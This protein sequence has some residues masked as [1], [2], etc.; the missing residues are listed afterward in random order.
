MLR[1]L[2]AVT[3]LTALAGSA[4]GQSFNV[5]L[6][7]YSFD[8]GSLEFT[9][10]GLAPPP[11]DYWG[12]GRRGYWNHATVTG[13]AS[14]NLADLNNQST[15]VSIHTPWPRV[16]GVAS[17]NTDTGVFRAMMLD[18]FQVDT[19]DNQDTYE[20]HNLQPGRYAVYVYF[21]NSPSGINASV[22]VSNVV[23][24]IGPVTGGSVADTFRFGK[25]YTVARSDVAADGQ[26]TI[27]VSRIGG[28]QAIVSAMQIVKLDGLRPVMHINDNATGDNSGTSWENAMGSLYGA[29]EVLEAMYAYET[30]TTAN[31]VDFD[32]WVAGGVYTATPFTSVFFTDRDASLRFYDG[33]RIFGGFAGTENYLHQR[34]FGRNTEVIISGSIGGAGT[35]D[36]TRTLLTLIGCGDSTLVE[37]VTISG[38]FDDE[39]GSA[40][41]AG[42]GGGVEIIPDS[43]FPSVGND[44]GPV[45][46]DVAFRNN[47]ALREGGA[48]WANF[49][50]PV[51]ERCVFEANHAKITGNTDADG[52]AVFASSADPVFVNCEFTGNS[53]WDDGAAVDLKGNGEEAQLV[54][55]LMRGN[56]G[57]SSTLHVNQSPV[58]IINSL[59]AGNTNGFNAAAVYA[60]GESG[61]ILISSSTVAHNKALGDSSGVLLANGADGTV[62]NSIVWGNSGTTTTPG[63][64][65]EDSIKVVNGPTFV[66]FANST[67]E[68]GSAMQVP[69]NTAQFMN[70]TANPLFADPDG[71]DG[72]LGNTDDNYRL[73]MGSPAQDSGDITFVPLDDYDL[74][75]NGVTFEN[76]P[77]DLDGNDRF[78]DLAG[79]GQSGLVHAIDRGAFESQI[80]PC[81]PADLNADGLLD[82]AD[83]TGFVQAFQSG[84]PAADFAAPAGIFD[85]ADITAFIA[86]FLAGCP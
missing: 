10:P 4:L 7:I 35:S 28:G 44:S 20:F 69:F 29:S 19:V 14:F 74:D 53:A 18:G 27:N 51:F 2:T 21:A 80:D 68:N 46:R 65:G 36:D 37:H 26:L 60:T 23:G 72:I 32:L 59:I 42:R 40:Y 12:C 33:T 70:S 71:A 39:P 85:L 81:G 49:I 11:A 1:H 57:G 52:G 15:S 45:F 17:N 5:E 66:A 48:V 50:D 43:E 63:F 13:P 30:E 83:I 79:I 82:L 54:N 75:G 73:Q 78:V 77:L 56:T 6:G 61:D 62:F 84:Q 76:L 47:A 31:T 8:S 55:C 67:I 34:E 3:L 64:E 16:G 22:G 25:N 24:G 86:A 38:G 58:D 9:E 41:L